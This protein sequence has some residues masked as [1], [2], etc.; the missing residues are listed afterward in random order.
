MLGFTKVF[1]HLVGCQKVGVVLGCSMGKSAISFVIL[2]SEKVITNSIRQMQT[3]VLFSR[4]FLQIYI[5]CL[6]YFPVQIT[7]LVQYPSVFISS[8]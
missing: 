8:H 3:E 2:A 4:P 1:R 6:L 7:D 5:V